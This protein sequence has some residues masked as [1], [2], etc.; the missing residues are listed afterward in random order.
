[1]SFKNSSKRAAIKSR[2]YKILHRASEYENRRREQESSVDKLAGGTGVQG[3]DRWRAVVSTVMNVRFGETWG[4]CF[5][6]E[7]LSAC[8]E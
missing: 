3:R 5:L 6:G 1:L 7:K 8:R 2:Y 4:N